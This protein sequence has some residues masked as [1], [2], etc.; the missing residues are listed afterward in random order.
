MQRTPE[1]L[2]DF[3]LL[4]RKKFCPKPPAE[5]DD[6]TNARNATYCST[7]RHVHHCSNDAQDKSCYDSTDKDYCVGLSLNAEAFLNG[8]YEPD[9]L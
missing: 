8:V 1:L 9:F 4:L 3:F 2:L 6:K 7:N 5:A